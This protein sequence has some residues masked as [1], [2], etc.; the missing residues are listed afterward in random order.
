MNTAVTNLFKVIQGVSFGYTRLHSVPL[1][2]IA[3]CRGCPCRKLQNR[4]VA[5]AF[6]LD[7]QELR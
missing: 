7:P 6:A 3:R 5:R 1:Q 4:A 2:Q